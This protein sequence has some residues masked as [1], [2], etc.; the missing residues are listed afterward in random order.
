MLLVG[1]IMLL[2]IVGLAV[3][4]WIELTDPERVR[5]EFQFRQQMG[6]EISHCNVAARH[7]T[8]GL[9]LAVRVRHCVQPA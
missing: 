9:R 1:T 4:L 8:E 3:L 7:M 6:C 5:V 2:S